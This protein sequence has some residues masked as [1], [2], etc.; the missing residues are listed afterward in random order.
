[1][2][3]RNRS[4]VRDWMVII[5]V[6]ALTVHGVAFGQG[7]TAYD[8]PALGVEKL[9]LNLLDAISLTLDNDPNLLTKREDISSQYGRYQEASGA[10][11]WNLAGQ[12][13][14]EYRVQEL[15]ESGKQ[16]EID[17]RNQLRD[18]GH[19]TDQDIQLE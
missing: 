9:N 18:A 16:G 12:L 17:R 4:A 14:Y 6:G 13:Q 3:C 15:T 19:G 10:F 8:P 5:V 11:D 7:E 2:S 1:M